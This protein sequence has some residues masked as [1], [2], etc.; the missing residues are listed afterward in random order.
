MAKIFSA[1]S[2]SGGGLGK[3]AGLLDLYN[4]MSGGK[5]EQSGGVMGVV[6]EKTGFSS[7]EQMLEAS[8][9]PMAGLGAM[10]RRVMGGAKSGFGMGGGGFA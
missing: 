2:E 1:N 6:E 5:K 3:L 4:S 10:S 9:N 7:P 8:Y